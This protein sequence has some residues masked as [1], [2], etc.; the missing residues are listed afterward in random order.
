M[1]IKSSYSRPSRSD[2][3]N[4]RLPEPVVQPCKVIVDVFILCLISL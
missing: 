1:K 2:S 4:A 3:D